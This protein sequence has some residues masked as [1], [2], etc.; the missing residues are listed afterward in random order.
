MPH[1][2]NDPL[3]GRSM[4][5]S[6]FRATSGLIFALAMLS[7]ASPSSA[8]Q[9]MAPTAPSAVQ[10]SPG[11]PQSPPVPAQAIA[12]TQP[13]QAPAPSAVGQP[14]GAS[15]ATPPGTPAPPH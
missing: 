13:V 1:N 4:N 12:P 11:L 14:G 6:P 3:P 9:K 8:Q 15:P 7:L 5:M 2:L 10:P